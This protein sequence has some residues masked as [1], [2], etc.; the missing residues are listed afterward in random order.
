[1]E[2]LGRHDRDRAGAWAP[3]SASTELVQATFF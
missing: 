2:A 1:M 3:T